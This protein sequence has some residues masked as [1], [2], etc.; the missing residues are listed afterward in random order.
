M[1]IKIT[2]I[3]HASF[4]LGN[5]KIIYIDPWK[6]TASP[7]DANLVL[8]SHSHYDHYSAEDISKVARPD[9]DIIAP[10]DVIKKLGRGQVIEPNHTLTVHGLT[11]TATAAYNPA[12]QFHPRDNNWVGFIIEMDGKRIYYAGDTDIT[13]EMKGLT[14]IDVALMPVGGTYTTNAEEAAQA[15]NH[16]KPRLAIPYH[17]GDIV[18]GESDAQT[19]DL[20]T[21]C[22]VKILQPGESMT[23]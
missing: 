9:T 17:F 11:I 2:W 10:A 7:H 19:F 22:P 5:G 15:C 1:A 20:E 8:V 18:G 13:E 12:K 16:F 21:Q 4:R 23:I 3:N 14:H 6:L